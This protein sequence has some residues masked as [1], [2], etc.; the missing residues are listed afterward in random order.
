M[1]A[2]LLGGDGTFGNEFLNKAVVDRHLA[3]LAV[4]KEVA[5]RVADVR[6]GQHLTIVWVVDHGDRGDRCAHSGLT[7]IVDG[8]VVNIDVGCRD[9]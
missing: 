6:D 8:A 3:Q 9:C 1:V 5:A 2:G 7:G 4:A